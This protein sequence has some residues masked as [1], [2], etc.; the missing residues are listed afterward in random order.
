M[1]K[2]PINLSIIAFPKLYPL[3]M[4]QCQR[5]F[6]FNFMYD[7]KFSTIQLSIGLKYFWQRI[8]PRIETITIEKLKILT[9]GV[10]NPETIPIIK[11]IAARTVKKNE[12]AFVRLS[13]ILS[14]ISTYSLYCSKCLGSYSPYSYF[15]VNRTE[16]KS[17]SLSFIF[18]SDS[19]NCINY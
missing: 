5:K 1:A 17:S 12:D 18:A 8:K 16:A 15:D 6:L 7:L 3:P 9:A 10:S 13:L 4:I 11:I 19:S 14:A 2:W